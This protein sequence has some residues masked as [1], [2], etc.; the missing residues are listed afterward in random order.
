MQSPALVCRN[1]A[2]WIRLDQRFAQPA[3]AFAQLAYEA[4]SELIGV[5][6]DVGPHRAAIR[7]ALARRMPPDGRR[8]FQLPCTMKKETVND[9]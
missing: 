2:L 8:N 5:I 3:D 4:T 6:Q 1:E 7:E 9:V